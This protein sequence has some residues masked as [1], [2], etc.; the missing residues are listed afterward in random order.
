MFFIAKA[1]W[2]YG[3]WPAFVPLSAVM[4]GGRG[5]AFLS[6]KTEELGDMMAARINYLSHHVSSMG[7][8]VQNMAGYGSD[9]VDHVG[10][11]V[12]ANDFGYPRNFYPDEEE[13]DDEDEYEK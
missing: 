4:P 13:D 3:H 5:Q 6:E 9:L 2:G 10:H 11:I 7:H 12:D 1:F 8:M